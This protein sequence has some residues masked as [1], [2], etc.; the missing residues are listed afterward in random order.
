MET[1]LRARFERHGNGSQV[2]P[3]GRAARPPARTRPAPRRWRAVAV[4][5]T[6]ERAPVA[7]DSRHSNPAHAVGSRDSGCHTYNATRDAVDTAFAIELATAGHVMVSVTMCSERLFNFL[8]E[9]WLRIRNQKW[10]GFFSMLP[11]SV[12]Q[13]ACVHNPEQQCLA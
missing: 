4:G 3:S 2:A 13:N 12:L 9:K 11:E 7:S 10:Q 8:A 5:G 1:L 6:A